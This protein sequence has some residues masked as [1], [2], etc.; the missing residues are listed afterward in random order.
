MTQ[1]RRT[2]PSSELQVGQVDLQVTGLRAEDAMGRDGR[3]EIKS[4]LAEINIQKRIQDILEQPRYKG[5]VDGIISGEKMAFA[6]FKKH[7]TLSIV[8]VSV[9][10]TV[11]AV[12]YEFGIRHGEDVREVINF[13]KPKQEEKS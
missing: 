6:M 10:T 13:L 7:M 2:M 5:L 3:V 12:A 11:A 1:E 8:V 9:G 4:N